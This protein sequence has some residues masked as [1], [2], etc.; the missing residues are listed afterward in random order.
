MDARGK[1]TFNKVDPPGQEMFH[2]Q[3]SS[4]EREITLK[5][6]K[7]RTQ[8]ICLQILDFFLRL[9]IGVMKIE[10]AELLHVILIIR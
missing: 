8:N 5:S 9:G 4:L 7:I 3:K 2:G 10:H 1:G 6:K